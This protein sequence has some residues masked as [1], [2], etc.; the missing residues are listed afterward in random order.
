MRKILLTMILAVF[1]VGLEAQN[2]RDE[3]YDN[4][5]CSASNFMA[6]PGPTQLQLTPAPEGKH[7]FYI[8]HYGRHGSRYH[9]KAQTYEIPY[10]MMA[11]ADSLG[12][13][14]TLG[15]EVLHRLKM[16]RDD[17]LDQYGELTTLGAQQHQQIMQRMVERFP[18]VFV[19]GAPIDARSTT[20]LRCILSMENALMQLSR[21]RPTLKFHHNATRRDS[22]Y[23]NLQDKQLS[24]MKMDSAAQAAYQTFCKQYERNDR[25][26]LSLFN[27]TA[28]IRLHVDS[29]ELNYYLFRVASN[30]QSTDMSQR[31]TLYDLFTD[32]ELYRN[33][34]KENAWWYINYGSYPLNGGLQPY[35]QRNLLRKIILDA[36]SC[37]CLKKPG[38]QLRFGHDTI[39]LSLT[40]L[41][42]INNYGLATNDL[43][44]LDRRGWVNYRVFP[45]AGNLQFI[46]YRANPQDKEILFKVLLNENEV[47]LPLK[48]DKKPYY[49]WTDFREYFLKKLDAYEKP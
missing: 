44:L 11:S 21:M 26:M 18:E 8:S 2:I 32:E 16:I 47:E 28:Y 31:M 7:P 41:L 36:D 39:L 4:I 35:T 12:K 43:E 15:K 45:M 23:L 49:R 24:S 37:F 38:A 48:S 3:I 33:W 30:L 34:K 40:C 13:L 20:V 14:T 10:R 1:V 9:N 22:Y 29:K 25:L 6:Y 42:E 5:R 19:D 17:A 27:D 46:F